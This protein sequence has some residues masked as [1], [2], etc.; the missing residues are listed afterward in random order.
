MTNTVFALLDPS[1][2]PWPWMGA[3]W[4]V[5]HALTFVIICVHCLRSRREATSTLLWLFLSLSF[6][7]VGPFLYVTIG[8]DRVPDKGF[9]KTVTDEKL[10]AERKAREADPRLLAY[11][12]H[13]REAVSS[14]PPTP[15]GAELNRALNQLFPN[16]PLLGGN[17]V[18]PLVTGDEAFPQMFDAIRGATHHVHL[19]SFMICNDSVGRDLLDLLADKAASGVEVRVMYDRFGSTQAH[20]SGF[21]R[22]YRRVPN[23]EIIGWTQA[24]PLKRQFQVN[25]RNHRKIVVIDGHTAFC[26][27]MNIKDL[28]V[29]TNGR[30]P[31][32]D[33]HFMV[34]GPAA[35]EL[36]YTF[37]R[38]WYFMTD[39]DPKDLLR[40]EYFPEVPPGG[41]ALV[42]VINSGPSSEMEVIADVFFTA[43]VA[44]QKQILVATPYFV[45]TRDIVRALRTAALRGVDVRLIVPEKNNHFYAGLAGRALYE[46]L[47]EAG[48]R[49]FARQPPFMHAKALLVDDAF[50]LVGTAN[51]DVRSLRLNYETN[52]VVYD[53]GFVN[54]M[55]EIVLEDEALS[56]AL[57]LETWRSRPA[58]QRCMENLAHLMTPV[59]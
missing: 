53:D 19:Q 11:W 47:L 38:D 54:R 50:A 55:K 43:I 27:G 59:L 56:R 58:G 51:L 45:P 17:D 23:L 46:E 10:L 9:R 29:T 12:R 3:V 4:G 49:V 44:A 5:I 35:L 57:R 15:F 42:R 14:Q 32:R 37:M 28:N 20:F 22:P 36:Q 13:L 7:I 40:E 1:Q 21:F 34:R 31:D 48:V 39:Y 30:P 6:P 33:Y 52:L 41:E 8:I 18:V 2:W 26:G 16:H 24:N 25:L